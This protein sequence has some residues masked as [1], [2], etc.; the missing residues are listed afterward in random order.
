MLG[1]LIWSAECFDSNFVSFY[2]T[3]FHTPPI[4]HW[5]L[6]NFFL[7]YGLALY[8]Y[9]RFARFFHFSLL[10][11]SCYRRCREASARKQETFGVACLD[12]SVSFSEGERSWLPSWC[13]RFTKGVSSPKVSRTRGARS[14]LR[15]TKGDDLWWFASRFARDLR[16]REASASAKREANHQ[17]CRFARP[18]R[19]T[20]GDANHFWSLAKR[21]RKAISLCEKRAKRNLASRRSF[22][23]P[24]MEPEAGQKSYNHIDAFDEGQAPIIKLRDG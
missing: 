22:I 1:E 24:K 23:S 7:I 13:S 17:R 15:F 6:S 18:L 2:F 10:S 14:P 5:Q 20:F 21:D 8:W 12:Q 16:C 19:E 11:L 4:L 9:T 3:W